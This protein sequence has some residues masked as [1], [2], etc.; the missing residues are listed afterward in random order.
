MFPLGASAIHATGSM[1]DTTVRSKS[2]RSTTLTLAS[3]RCTDARYNQLANPPASD[4]STFYMTPEALASGF[5]D[6][7]HDS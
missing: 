7:D 4:L 5:A 1:A 2:M 3:S 6:F